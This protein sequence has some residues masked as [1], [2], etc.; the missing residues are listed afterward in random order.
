MTNGYLSVNWFS[1]ICY[2][3]LQ[4]PQ[5]RTPLPLITGPF[6]ILGHPRRHCFRPESAPSTPRRHPSRRS[7]PTSRRPSELPR[8]CLPNRPLPEVCPVPITSPQWGP[9]PPLAFRRRLPHRSHP[10][11][12]QLFLRQVGPEFRFQRPVPRRHPRID[13]ALR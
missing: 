11:Q 12:C 1:G 13:A 4:H 9:H 2:R 3:I 10:P 7:W 5:T 8:L 6:L